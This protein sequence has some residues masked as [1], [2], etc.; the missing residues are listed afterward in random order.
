MM[1]SIDIVKK[2]ITGRMFKLPSNWL[3]QGYEKKI[4]CDYFEECSM[5]NVSA[6]ESDMCDVNDFVNYLIDDD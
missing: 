3:K 4:I 1:I 5:I 6:T 2:T